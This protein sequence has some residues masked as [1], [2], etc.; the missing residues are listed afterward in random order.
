MSRK[1]ISERV[2][3]AFLVGYC[4]C[5]YKIDEDE[6]GGEVQRASWHQVREVLLSRLYVSPLIGIH[7]T[8]EL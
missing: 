5:I 7:A 8:H 2:I 4:I 1:I 6:C 3:A